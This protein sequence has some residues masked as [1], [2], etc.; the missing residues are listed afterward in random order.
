[1]EEEQAVTK[2]ERRPRDEEHREVRG[3]EALRAEEFEYRGQQQRQSG[4]GQTV[5]LAVVG[6]AAALSQILAD[7][8]VERAVGL[9]APL[10]VEAQQ[11][12][13]R[14]RGEQPAAVAVGPAQELVDRAHAADPTRCAG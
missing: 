2:G 1:V 13:Q 4:E 14:G 6:Q 11:V 12:H 9:D 5:E 8:Q 10:A 7:G 3:H